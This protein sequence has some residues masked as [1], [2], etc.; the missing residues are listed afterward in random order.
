VTFQFLVFGQTAQFKKGR[1]DIQKFGGF[2]AYLSRLDSRSGKDQGNARTVIPES[3]L[4][5]DPLFSDMP[6]MIRP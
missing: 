6:T 3:I 5:G 2:L 4:P 1:I